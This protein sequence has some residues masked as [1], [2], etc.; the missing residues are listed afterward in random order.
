MRVR[1]L[2]RGRPE[3]RVGRRRRAVEGEAG[4]QLRVEQGETLGDDA[5]VRVAEQVDPRHAEVHDQGEEHFGVRVH[6]RRPGGQRPRLPGAQRLRVDHGEVFLQQRGA[7]V[8]VLDP[9]PAG[10]GDQHRAGSGDVI[11]LPGAVRGEA[12]CSRCQRRHGGKAR[13]RRWTNSSPRIHYPRGRS[14]TSPMTA[15]SAVSRAFAGLS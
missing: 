1:L 11:H 13:R 4:D 10:V 2:P 3:L 15:P 5:A 8:G 6:V 9:G 14:S 7:Q 12:V